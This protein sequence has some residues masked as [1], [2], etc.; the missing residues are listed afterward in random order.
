MSSPDILLFDLGGVLLDINFD[1]VYASWARSA[2]CDM[3]DIFGKMPR[4]TFDRYQIGAIDDTTFYAEMI[5]A[6][7]I[8]ISEE[9]FFEGWNK[10]FVGEKNGIYDTVFCGEV[11]G[12]YDTLVLAT[13][14][15]FPLYLLSN[16]NPSHY[17]YFSRRFAG[18]LKHFK[19]KFI[20]ST[21]G[22]LKPDPAIFHLVAREIGVT[23]DRIMFFDDTIENV[24]GA[25]AC[26][27]QAV[28][29]TSQATVIETISG[30]S[31][32]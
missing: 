30:L 3:M 7:G 1:R 17:E 4:E 27:L 26:G 9:D 22:L 15:R 25:K 28:H 11:L 8:G 19:W 14:K 32:P 23:M 16:T 29:V 18:L 31:R 2:S 5:E 24:E 10:V 21:I 12:I 13:K 20:S 6:L